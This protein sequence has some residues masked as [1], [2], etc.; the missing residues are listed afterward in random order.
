MGYDPPA[1]KMQGGGS[2]NMSIRIRIGEE[3]RDL[4][5]ASEAWINEQIRRRRQ[6]SSEVCL[7]VFI[8]TGSLNMVLATSGCGSSGGSGGRPPNDR[9]RGIFDLWAK[10]GL[11]DEKFTAGSVIAFLQQLNRSI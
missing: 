7:K 11:D 3:E 10:R 9:E 6:D 8:N 2:A 4:A 5:S 1:G